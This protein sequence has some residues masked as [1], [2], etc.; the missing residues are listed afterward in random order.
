MAAEGV[1]S[2]FDIAELSI[3]AFL[4]GSHG[5]G[6]RGGAAPPRDTAELAAARNSTWP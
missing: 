4:E 5:L 2:P 6:G 1:H 3:L